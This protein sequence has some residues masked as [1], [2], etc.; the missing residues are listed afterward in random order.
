MMKEQLKAFLT[1]EGYT[2]VVSNL[3]EFLVFLKKEY[4]HVCALFIIELENDSTFSKERYQAVYDSACKLLEKNGVT[5]MHILTVI[6]SD[7]QEHALEVCRE[8]KYA[9]V[10][11]RNVKTLVIEDGKVVD[12]YGLKSV[13]ER[14]LQEPGAAQQKIKETEEKILKE[15]KEREKKQLWEIYIPWVAYGLVALNI[16]VYIVCTA[17][18]NLLYN[19][20]EMS[21]KNTVGDG[22]WYRL[23]TSMFLHGN[24]AHLFNNMLILYLLG[25]MVEKRLG[26]WQFLLCYFVCGIV[27]GLTSLGAKY[28]SGID[29]YS[30]GASGAVYGMFGIALVTEFATINW[31]RISINTLRRMLLVILCII[32]SLYVDART[33]SIDYEAHVGGLCMGAMIGMAWYFNQLRKRRMRKHEN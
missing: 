14:F 21:L 15:L 5:E 24:L 23:I 2:A 16:V 9:W 11:N 31:R 3:P 12:F 1:M 32:I 8:D 20:G 10:M 29:A 19:I 25:N 30:I 17:T 33:A 26:R 27:A 6:V 22:Q 13:F 4:R 7:N 28:F 18:G